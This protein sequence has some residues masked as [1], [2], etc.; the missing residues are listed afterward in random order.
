MAQSHETIYYRNGPVM[1]TDSRLALGHTTLPL[2][3]IVSVAATRKAKTG[4]SIPV[5]I[6][7]IVVGI[8][9]M[10]CG[11]SQGTSGSDVM[12]QN[13]AF[14]GTASYEQTRQSTHLSFVMAAF[15]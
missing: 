8:G 6:A 10:V 4:L 3:S 12:K 13:A 11:I 14:A 1:L 5:G 9:M 2:S 15:G 7:L